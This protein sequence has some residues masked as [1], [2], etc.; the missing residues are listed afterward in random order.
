MAHSPIEREQQVE[1]CAVLGVLFS[2]ITSVAEIP[3]LLSVYESLR[4]ARTSSTLQASLVNRGVFHMHDGEDQQSRD[5]SM[6]GSMEDALRHARTS[7]HA[8]NANMWADKQKNQELFDYDAEA[9]A[10]AWFRVSKVKL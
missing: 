4:I 2:R 9:V 1:D 7:E 3:K 6:R 10:E 5:I 8:G